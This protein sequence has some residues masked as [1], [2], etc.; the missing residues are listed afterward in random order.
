MYAK[1]FLFNQSSRKANAVVL[2]VCMKRGFCRQIKNSQHFKAKVYDT[3][4]LIICFNDLRS[5]L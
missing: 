4:K 2:P 1:V 5:V 3:L